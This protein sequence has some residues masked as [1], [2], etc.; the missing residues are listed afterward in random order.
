MNLTACARSSCDALIL[1]LP[2]D[3]WDSVL[4]IV[5]YYAKVQDDLI[6]AAGPG[7]WNDPDEVSLSTLYISD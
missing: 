7:H 1:H 2:Q 3:S 5:D 6:P 4:S